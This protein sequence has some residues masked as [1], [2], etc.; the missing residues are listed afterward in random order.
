VKFKPCNPVDKLISSADLAV[1]GNHAVV[2]L[3]NRG[4]LAGEITL[5]K[6]DGY[7]FLMKLGLEEDK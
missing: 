7:E 6:E 2:R 1:V 4:G 5:N 3:W